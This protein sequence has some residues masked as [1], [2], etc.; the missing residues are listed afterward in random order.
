M[1]ANIVYVNSFLPSKN[2]ERKLEVKL[3]EREGVKERAQLKS[4]TKVLIE[5]AMSVT[6]SQAKQTHTHTH[7]HTSTCA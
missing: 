7:A 4:V 6:G 3:K 2:Q 1:S 5:R